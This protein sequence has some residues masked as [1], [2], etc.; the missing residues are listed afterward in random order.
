[1]DQQIDC[2]LKL[3]PKKARQRRAHAFLMNF[4]L[5]A[6]FHKLLIPHNYVI[7]QAKPHAIPQTLSVFYPQ[8]LEE[9]GFLVGYYKITKQKFVF[10]FLQHNHY[11]LLFMG[12]VY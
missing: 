3:A 7:L 9:T 8:F 12:A 1:M 10:R 11:R 5:C 2:S 6:I 4:F